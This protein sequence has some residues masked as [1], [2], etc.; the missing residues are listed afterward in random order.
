MTNSQAVEISCLLKHTVTYLTG[1]YILFQVLKTFLSVD[2]QNTLQSILV[3]S[4]DHNFASFDNLI[5]FLLRTGKKS[6]TD[7]EYNNLYVIQPL[8]LLLGCQIPACPIAQDTQNLGRRTK[9]C[10]YFTMKQQGWWSSKP[11]GRLKYEDQSGTLI[12]QERNIHRA[13]SK[14][15]S[16][17]LQ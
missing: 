10:H 5:S 8:L 3:L 15:L 6:L 16:S 1:S 4:I 2:N 12:V 14:L 7:T 13:L 9:I 17:I 11:E